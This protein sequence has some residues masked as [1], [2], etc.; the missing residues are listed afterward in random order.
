MNSETLITELINLKVKNQNRLNKLKRKWANQQKTGIPTNAELLFLYRQAIKKKKITPQPELERLLQKRKIRTLSG[1]A[2]VAVLT[3]PHPCPGN[4]LF[5]P[6]EKSI[7][8]SYLS[9]EPAVMRAIANNFDP[10]RQVSERIRALEN[11]GHA[12]DKIELIVMGGT[13]SSFPIKYQTD[14]IKKCFAGAN[15]RQ[16]I[17]LKEAQK[18][19]ETSKHRI[20]ALTLETRPDQVNVKNIA[21]WRELGATKIELGIQIINEEILQKNNRGHGV[22]EII[23]ATALLR[24]A[25]FKICYHLMPGLFG[26]TPKKDLQSFTAIFSRPEFQ[27]DF[28]KIYPTV[29]TKG[30][31]LYQLWQQ[32]KYRPYSDKQLFSLLLK[33]KLLTPPYCRIIRLIRDIP[34]E[35]IEAGN[36]VSNLRENLQKYLHENSLHCRCLR[37]REAREDLTDLKK[38]K[39]FQQKY[40]VSGGEEFFLEYSSPNRQKLFAFL[41]LFLPQNRTSHFLPELKGSA[42]IREVHTYGRLTSIGKKSQNV[43]HRGLGTLLTQEAI[44]IARRNGFKSL[45]VISGVGVRGFYRKIGFRKKGS[46]MN[47]DISKN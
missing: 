25:G 8:K 17:S 38:A 31:E 15:G 35:S 30:T 32:K 27:P 37:C 26:A 42:I 44:N 21:V 5:C 41:R 12:T 23:E 24:S 47:K 11:N 13:W 43:Q 18:I 39:L 2:P 33:M 22:K 7:P 3:K 28:I 34:N 20:V 14:F 16:A 36:L 1:V 40:S 4:C 9:N 10:Y 29:V 19:N 45:A 46:Y 6:T